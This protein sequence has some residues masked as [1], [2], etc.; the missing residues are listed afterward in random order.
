MSNGS[1]S[2]LTGKS[3]SILKD[4]GKNWRLM[5]IQEGEKGILAERLSYKECR[6][7]RGDEVT[8]REI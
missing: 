3:V 4:K 8:R 7:R 5:V 2:S 1:N 6:L